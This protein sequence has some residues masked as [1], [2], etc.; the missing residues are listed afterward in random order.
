MPHSNKVISEKE[1]DEM[2]SKAIRKV[3]GTKENDL[4]KY[5]PGPNGGYMHHFT[6]R[7]IK[8]SHPDQ[9]FSLLKEFIINSDIPRALDPKPR[10][11]RGSRKRRD[12]VSFT[13]TD[14]E[15]VLDLARRVGDDDLMARFSPKR[16][17]P[18]LKRELL[19][20]VRD[21]RVCQ[22][23]WTAYCDAIATLQSHEGVY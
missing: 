8:N 13:R 5:I 15:K 22:D 10:A 3:S 1:M 9:L 16:S 21:N 20:S 7:K 19:R 12:F 18:T 4:C 6:M 14:I 23:L 17:L 2:I 11:P